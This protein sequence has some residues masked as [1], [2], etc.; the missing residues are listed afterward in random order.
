MDS[1]RFLQA[2]ASAASAGSASAG[3]GREIGFGYPS[4]LTRARMIIASHSSRVRSKPSRM[5]ALRGLAVLALGPAGQIVGGA[6]GQI[7]HG[8]DAVFAEGNQHLGRDAR[9]FLEFVGDAELVALGIELG[10]DW[11]R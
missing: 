7:L 1:H 11:A 6:T 4:G 8:L 10:L 9:Q 2:A 5:P 3:G